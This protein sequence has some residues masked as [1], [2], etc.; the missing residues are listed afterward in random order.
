MAFDYT[1]KVVGITGAAG[2][3]GIGF[4]IAKKF[5]ESGA[6]VFICDINQQA[7]EDAREALKT[8]GGS[9]NL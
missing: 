9:G 8:V 7:L 6:R 1:G 4:A 5:L 2:Q 3:A